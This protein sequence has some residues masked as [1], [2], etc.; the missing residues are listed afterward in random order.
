M[1]QRKR[2]EGFTLVEVI[3][4]MLVLTIICASLLT[5]F[6]TA[7]KSS[8]ATKKARS[9]EVL[10]ANVMEYAKAGG[11]RFALIFGGTEDTG[12]GS[13]RVVLR[14]VSE[15]F[16][17][18]DVEIEKDYDVVEYE[19]ALLNDFRD[20]LLGDSTENVAWISLPE[21]GSVADAQALATFYEMHVQYVDAY[22]EEKRAEWITLRNQQEE[23][24]ENGLTPTPT[25]IP[26]PAELMPMDRSEL[27]AKTTRELI[28][29][30]E[31]VAFGKMQL[32]A[33][34]SYTLS[35]EVKI[36]EGMER[37]VSK[38][39]YRSRV[40]D[41][42]DDILGGE[43]CLDRVLVLYTPFSGGNESRVIRVLDT[44]KVLDT[45]LFLVW[46]EET[47]KPLE[48]ELYAQDLP[49][50]TN[51]ENLVLTFFSSEGNFYEPYRLEVYSAVDLDEDVCST[52]TYYDSLIAT[53]QEE[54][55]AAVKVTVSDP[56]SGGVVARVSGAYTR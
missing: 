8:L 9:A 26:E 2:N 4:A 20:V 15:G 27:P 45:K 10:A 7:A 49:E 55:I 37:T 32:S 56:D 6:S 41:S 52:V 36:P 28:L 21:Q 13:D 14:G 31:P 12:T 34:L 24:I 50:R 16:F 46:S 19:Q 44:G 1:R 51:G 53:G 42:G 11:E 25:P 47:R 5:A 43:D 38:E 39:V 33:R 35:Q 30:A 17:S 23:E 18:Y 3:V 22:N 29:S 48:Q 54:R 40:F